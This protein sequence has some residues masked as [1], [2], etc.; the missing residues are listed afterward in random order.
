MSYFLLEWIR[1]GALG[2]FV[3]FAIISVVV[4]M[5]DKG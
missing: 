1:I 3:I 2:L 4:I 5:R